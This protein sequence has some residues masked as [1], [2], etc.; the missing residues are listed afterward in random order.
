MRAERLI[1]CALALAALTHAGGVPAQVVVPV[2]RTPYHVPAFGNE[3]VSVLNVFIPGHRT[4]G[5]HRHSTDTLGV[6]IGEGPRTT[7]VQGAAP[8]APELRPNGTVTFAF[9]SRE[10]LVH[11]VTQT[12]DEPFHNV[13]VSLTQSSPHGFTPSARDG[14]AAYTRVLDNERVRA[15][16]LVLAPGEEAPAITQGAPGL[17]IVVTGGEL[18]ERVPGAPDR[19]IAPRA[20]EFFWQDAGTTRAVRN[21][22]TTRLELVEI[23]LK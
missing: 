14:I 11:A 21:V 1:S 22:G 6:L 19:G 5:F 12:G 7:Q 16:R 9:Y 13:V 4:S 2:E 15:W 23:E 3:L 20:G 8:I 10:P 18:I 17:R